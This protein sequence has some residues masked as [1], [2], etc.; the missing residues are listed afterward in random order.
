[1]IFVTGGTGFIGKALIQSLV[2]FGK[3]VRT[4]LRPSLDTPDLPL[5]VPVEVAVCSL[6]D[7]RGLRA[8]LKDVTT[9][10]HLAGSER[11]GSR[12]D[13][14]GVDV[15]GTRVLTEVAAQAGVEKFIFLSHLGAD[16]MSAYPVLKAKALAEGFITHSNLV[17]TI[18]RSAVVFGPGDQFTTSLARLLKLSPGFF[19]IPG[20]GEVYLQPLWIEDLVSCLVFL[21]EERTTDNQIFSIGG[22]EYFTFRDILGM[23]MRVIGVRRALVQVSPADLRSITLFLEQFFPQFPISIFWVDYLAADRTCPLDTLPRIFG[24]MPARFNYQLDYLRT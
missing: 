18:L 24:L 23:V 19:L 12:A 1:M 16:R 21:L 22:N 5:G 2:A 6:T 13:L 11:R 3:P 9:I 7:E 10:Y 20:S 17:Y 4:L 14:D 15:Q 8:A